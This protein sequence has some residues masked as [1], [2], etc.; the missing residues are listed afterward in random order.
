VLCGKALNFPRGGGAMRAPSHKAGSGWRRPGHSSSKRLPPGILGPRSGTRGS[1]ERETAGLAAE[2]EALAR[3]AA[4][5]DNL[6]GSGDHD[7]DG[8]GQRKRKPHAPFS[9]GHHDPKRLRAA[10]HERHGQDE[11]DEFDDDEDDEYESKLEAGRRGGPPA[12]GGSVRQLPQR[13]QSED[14]A[15]AESDQA[16]AA[17]LL[18]LCGRWPSSPTAGE[19]NLKVKSRCH[20]TT[21]CTTYHDI[22]CVF[23]PRLTRSVNGLIPCARSQA[24]SARRLGTPSLRAR[25]RSRR[26]AGPSSPPR[27]RT[28]R[29]L[30]AVVE[31]PPWP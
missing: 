14:E 24:P 7:A 16:A 19:S 30:E 15:E 26:V 20:Y 4:A 21:G 27:A 6:Q 1:V 5:L 8:G 31:A 25:R 9:P 28:A 29:R 3:W 18:A 17:D 13:T 10:Y 12:R 23:S 2:S 22:T 11:Y